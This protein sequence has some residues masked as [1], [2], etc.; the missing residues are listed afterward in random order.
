MVNYVQIEQGWLGFIEGG[1][2]DADIV[3]F[4]DNNSALCVAK[5]EGKPR[6]RHVAL[7]WHRVKDHA[8][9]LAF[10]PT[11]RMVA[12]ALTKHVAQAQLQLLFPTHE[13]LLSEN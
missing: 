12:D 2:S 8:S 9:Q 10:C 5:E 13:L 3:R 1:F 6:S 11:H 4:C 7:R